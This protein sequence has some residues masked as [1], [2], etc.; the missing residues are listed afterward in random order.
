MSQLTEVRLRILDP[1]GVLYFE[2][3]TELPETLIP[4]TAYIIDNVYYVD[5]KQVDLKISDERIIDWL[6]EQDATTDSVTL[7]ALKVC[8][9]HLKMELEVVKTS[10]G[11]DSDEYA[12][13]LSMWKVYDAEIADL[14]DDIADS[15]AT[16]PNKRYQQFRVP[17]WALEL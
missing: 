11:A 2:T 16:T 6:A 9:S 15:K 12:D 17:C 8:R 4:Q 1:S 13:I 5:G 10:S 7:K 3:V 14:Q